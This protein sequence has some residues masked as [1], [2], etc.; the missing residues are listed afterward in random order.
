MEDP[1]A[2][3]LGLDPDEVHA[4][5]HLQVEWYAYGRRSPRQAAEAVPC[6]GARDRLREREVALGRLRRRGLQT[7]DLP[8]EAITAAMLNRYLAIRYGVE[9]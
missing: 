6:T 2:K 7:L 9:R 4:A 3:V 1:I 8:T 5:A